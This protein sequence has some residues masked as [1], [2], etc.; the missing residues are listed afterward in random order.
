MRPWIPL[1]MLFTV[2]TCYADVID[3]AVNQ[4]I[5]DAVRRPMM[6]MGAKEDAVQGVAKGIAATSNIKVITHTAKRAKKRVEKKTYRILQKNM[7]IK[8]EYAVAAVV[9]G[10]GATQGKVGTEGIKYRIKPAK[11]L[12]IRPD[13]MYNFKGREV[14]STLNLKWEW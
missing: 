2:L 4:A 11:N 1:I 3:D 7:G 14:S 13:V 8:K 5:A 6:K 10:M 9:L 12:S